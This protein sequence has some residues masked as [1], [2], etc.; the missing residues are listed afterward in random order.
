MKCACWVARR[1]RRR[2]AMASKICCAISVPTSLKFGPCDRGRRTRRLSA[3]CA[4]SRSN[5]R[6]WPA[7]RP[8]STLPGRR[9]AARACRRCADMP[10]A[11]AAHPADMDEAAPLFAI[12]T[13]LV[14]TGP[15]S[16]TGSGRHCGGAGHCA[17]DR[18]AGT[19]LST[20][21]LTRHLLADDDDA[22]VV[23]AIHARHSHVYLQVF[24]A[25]GRT[26]T[27]PRLAPLVK[28][29]ARLPRC[30]PALSARPRNSSPTALPS[31]T[32]AAARR[33]QW[34]ARHPC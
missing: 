7:L 14:T 2:C 17:R 31:P 5:T 30:R 4:Y 15:G 13:A 18:Q 9:I 20:P 26:I 29:C 24:A 1:R 12:L 22:P 21:S 28:Q 34:R 25:G 11:D 8:C 10:S 33:R 16:F 3:P 23:V 27:G 6:S 32:N 19:G